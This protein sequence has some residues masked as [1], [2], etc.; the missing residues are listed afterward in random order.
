MSST[1]LEQRR[2]PWYAIRVQSK[3]EALVSAA[4]RGKSFEEFL[5]TYQA[6]RQWSDRMK[7]V[8]LPLFP[9]YLFCRLDVEGRL[10]PILT[11]PGVISIVG[12][13][14]VP[15]ALADSE[16]DAIQAVI[17][18]GLPAV[19]WLSLLV[20]SRV[21]IEKGPLTGLEGTVLNLSKKYRLIVS[22]PLLQR[23]V[24]VEIER[25]WAR[26]IL[27]SPTPKAAQTAGMLQRSEF[28]A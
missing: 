12:A 18:S 10:L 27:S 24:A 5:P 11:T 22:V 20:G 21:Y 25:E 1:S 19:P 8:T 15:I 2:L 3:L 16:I 7:S 17:R 13:G 14:K 6:R 23:S 28:V 26:P 9:G 4:L